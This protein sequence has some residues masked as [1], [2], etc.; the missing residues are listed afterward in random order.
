MTGWVHPALSLR[1]LPDTQTGQRGNG[2]SWR[3]APTRLQLLVSLPS[4]RSV[5]SSSSSSPPTPPPPPPLHP[6]TPPP[7]LPPPQCRC[8][9]LS[10]ME[11]LSSDVIS[12]LYLSFFL[13]L[14]VHT[15]YKNKTKH[16]YMHCRYWITANWLL[17][18]WHIFQPIITT[19]CFGFVDMKTTRQS[20]NWASEWGGMMTEVTLN[21]VN[22]VVGVS[23][24]AGHITTISGLFLRMVPEKGNS[25]QLLEWKWLVD[26]RGQRSWYGIMVGNMESEQELKLPLGPSEMSHNPRLPTFDWHKTS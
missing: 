21:E 16:Y 13:Q 17:Y 19:Q 3:S 12:V 7:P 14:Y 10:L 5:S 25:I 1:T 9:S 4:A 26:V 6:P 24:P 2:G 20:P 15:D 23:Q 22:V 18:W 8:F 11:N